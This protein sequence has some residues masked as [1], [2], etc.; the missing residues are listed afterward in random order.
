MNTY[1]VQHKRTF[2]AA[3]LVYSNQ[4]GCMPPFDLSLPLFHQC[5][6]CAKTVTDAAVFWWFNSDGNFDDVLTFRSKL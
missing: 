5:A 1:I 6:G 4:R 3:P 2:A